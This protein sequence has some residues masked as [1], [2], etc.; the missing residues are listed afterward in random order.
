MPQKSNSKSIEKKFSSAIPGTKKTDFFHCSVLSSVLKKE[1]CGK[2]W[3]RAEEIQIRDDG[4]CKELMAYMPC[5]GCKVGEKNSSLVDAGSLTKV[6]TVKLGR[7]VA[8]L[9]KVPLGL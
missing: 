9:P 2:R 5:R 8:N 1:S 3:I 6:K 4:V 7:A